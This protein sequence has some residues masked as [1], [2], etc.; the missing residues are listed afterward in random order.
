MADRRV[1]TPAEVRSAFQTAL[2]NIKPTDAIIVGIYQ[3]FSHQVGANVALVRNYR[4]EIRI[5]VPRT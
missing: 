5:Y 3:Q 4:D 1:G 2:E